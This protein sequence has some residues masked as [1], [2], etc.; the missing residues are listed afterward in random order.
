MG[1]YS[2]YQTVV[3]IDHP[4]FLH[5]FYTQL[6]L[7]DVLIVLISQCFH[8]SSRMIFRNSGYALATLVI[9][10]ALVAPVYVN[11]LLGG[12]AISLAILLTLASQYL[13]PPQ[14]G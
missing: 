10:I 12:A 7:T 5:T 2:L 4:D 1:L 8:P 13:F 3:G 9:R 14:R 6:I 11:V